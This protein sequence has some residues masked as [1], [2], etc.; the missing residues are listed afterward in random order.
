MQSPCSSIGRAWWCPDSTSIPRTLR[1]VAEVCRRL[2]GIPLAIELA[3]AR[4]KVLSVAQL[5]QRLD[6]QFALLSGT[7]RD[8][9]PHQQTLE[10]TLDWSYDFLSA[11][12]RLLFKRLSI[13]S[14]GFTL[15][16]A[17]QVCSGGEVVRD[18]VVSLL[19][20]LVETSLVMTADDD[21]ERYRLLEPISHYARMRLEAEGRD[22]AL[23]DL[24]AHFFIDLA[25]IAAPQLQGR[26]TDDR[27]PS[28]SSASTTT[29]APP[30]SGCSS[31]ATSRELSPSPERSAGS[32]SSSVTSPRAPSGWRRS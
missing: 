9:P 21:Q 8:M 11:A 7:L 29:C 32:G 28:A 18:H 12:E 6:Q 31:P 20:R 26:E 27:P 17:E 2:D 24:H 25:E 13:F 19:G 14:G 10:T 4:L 16:A 5:V 15:E 23:R 22:D 1:L 30:S 3:A